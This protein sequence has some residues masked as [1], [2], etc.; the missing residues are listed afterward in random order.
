MNDPIA[1]IVIPARN[2]EA[3]IGACLAAIAPQAKDILTVLVVNGTNDGTIAAARRTATESGLRLDIIDR[4]AITAGGVGSARTIGCNHALTKHLSIKAILTT[5]ADCIVA[6][7][8]VANTLAHLSHHDAVCGR[9][10]AMPEESS[11]LSGMD[12]GPATLEG[13][14]RELVLAFYRRHAPEAANPDVHHGEAAGASLAL[15][16]TAYDRTG[17]FRALTTGEDTDLVRRMKKAGLSVRHAPDV[18]AHASCRLD[19]RARGGMAEAL[20]LRLEGTDYRIGDGMPEADW[21]I[22]RA[23]AGRL[24]FWPPHVP[25][26]RRMRARDLAPQIA[27]LETHL[28]RLFAA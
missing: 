24:G 3:R 4:G 17:G 22:A 6:Q 9:V 7:D 18:V 16:R 2:E 23:E 27:R 8:W 10:E 21:L 11:I 1:A 14:Y 28:A 25:V 26:S 20:R 12:P 5:D 15:T 19:G 13:R